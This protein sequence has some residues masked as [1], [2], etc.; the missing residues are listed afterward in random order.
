M[1]MRMIHRRLKMVLGKKREGGWRDVRAE[2]GG[3]GPVHKTDA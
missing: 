1:L 3:W 2:E